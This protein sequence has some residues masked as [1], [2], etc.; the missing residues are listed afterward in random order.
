MLFACFERFP[1]GVVLRNS[2]QRGTDR[3]IHRWYDGRAA[4]GAPP[5]LKR[6]ITKTIPVLAVEKG[7]QNTKK[8]ISSRRV[9]RWISC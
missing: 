6:L 9:D 3:V 4:K 2:N 7:R 5:D 1:E 8:R